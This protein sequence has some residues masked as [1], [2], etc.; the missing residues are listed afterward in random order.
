MNTYRIF[1]FAVASDLPLPEA[2]PA[3]GEIPLCT[4]R[5]LGS[6]PPDTEPHEWIH[7][8]LLP[9]GSPWLS[10][11]RTA[12]GFLLRFSSLCDFVLSHDLASVRCRPVPAVPEETLRHILLDQVIPLWMSARGKVVLHASAVQSPVGALV[13]LGATGQGKSTIAASLCNGGFSLLTDD[14]IHLR[15]EGD[16]LVGVPSYPSLRLWSDTARELFGAA[17]SLL[18]VAHYTDKGRVGSESVRFRFT[19]EPTPIRA[20]YS[21]ECDTK[22]NGKPV[23]IVA[24]T[25]AESFFELLRSSH[26]LDLTD[27]TRL[28]DEFG[29]LSRIPEMVP[30]RRLFYPRDFAVLPHVRRLIMNDVEI[31]ALPSSEGY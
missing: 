2:H 5:F 1:D 12:G 25:A 13:F 26:R 16:R 17:P 21:I 20:V 8:W 29:F 7:H 23:S 28:G 3:P 24:M 19:A 27:R 22:S 6:E 15:I 31:Q 11:A 30:I 9:D 18:P 4:F 10:L 14:C